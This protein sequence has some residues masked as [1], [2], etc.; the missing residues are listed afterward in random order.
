[1]RIRITFMGETP[2]EFDE[3]FRG[4][5]RETKARVSVRPAFPRSHLH[6]F[7][8]WVDEETELGAV[9]FASF[10]RMCNLSTKTGGQQGYNKSQRLPFNSLRGL[11]SPLLGVDF[12]HLPWSAPT[13]ELWLE[14]DLLFWRGSNN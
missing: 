11:K 13:H 12:I 1:M 14:P 4:F 5:H 3:L 2:Y 8:I 9:P 7:H 10:L 6:L